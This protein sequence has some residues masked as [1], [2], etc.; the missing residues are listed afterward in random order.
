MYLRLSELTSIPKHSPIMG[1]F[2]KDSEGNWW[3]KT[4]GKGNKLRQ[5]VLSNEM[6]EAIARYRVNYLKLSPLP[7]PSETTPL[8]RHL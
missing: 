5:I 4:V 2:F 8:I 6:L 3:F 7:S 1:D